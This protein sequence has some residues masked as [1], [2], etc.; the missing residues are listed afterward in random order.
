VSDN[1]SHNAATPR[2]LREL[3]RSADT[4]KL[5]GCNLQ[6]EGHKPDQSTFDIRDNLQYQSYYPV[7]PDTVKRMVSIHAE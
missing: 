1:G 7:V 6:G 3:C 2:T 5:W 4:S